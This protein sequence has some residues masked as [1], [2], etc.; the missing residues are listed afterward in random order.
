M[1]NGWYIYMRMMADHECLVQGGITIAG[2][3]VTLH[4]EVASKQ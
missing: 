1:C 2:R 3:H 4:S